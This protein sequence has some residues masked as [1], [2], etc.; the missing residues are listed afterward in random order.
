MIG[1]APQLCVIYKLKLHVYSRM[2]N[3]L[4][5]SKVC[6][7][8]PLPIQINWG[9]NELILRLRAV[10]LLFSEVSVMQR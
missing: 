4:S 7:V 1:T 6:L 10:F 3:G 5:F 2:R 8:R 9:A